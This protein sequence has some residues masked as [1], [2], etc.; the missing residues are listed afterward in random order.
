CQQ[1][2]TLPFTF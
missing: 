1:Y 2:E